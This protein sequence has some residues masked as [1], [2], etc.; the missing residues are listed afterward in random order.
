MVKI[1]KITFFFVIGVKLI[2]KWV[3]YLNVHQML[4]HMVLSQKKAAKNTKCKM[5]AENKRNLFALELGCMC[6][7]LGVKIE[8]QGGLMFESF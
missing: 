7:C 4:K 8:I 5:I 3:A 6:V 1:I 2:E